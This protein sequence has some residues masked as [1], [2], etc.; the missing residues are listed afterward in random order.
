MSS[1]GHGGSWSD[2][3]N[4]NDIDFLCTVKVYEKLYSV[5]A[6][7]DLALATDEY[8][9]KGWRGRGGCYPRGNGFAT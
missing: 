8:S 7:A 1:G 3:E 5:A 4:N 6:R 2:K 9:Y